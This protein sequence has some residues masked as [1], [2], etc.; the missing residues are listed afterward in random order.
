MYHTSHT[1]IINVCP[2]LV[3]HKI[4]NAAEAGVKEAEERELSL[5][6]NLTAEDVA[7]EVGLTPPQEATTKSMKRRPK[8]VSAQSHENM[9]CLIW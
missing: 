2:H 7:V 3:P 1:T 9:R 4:S 5:S 8:T 6:V